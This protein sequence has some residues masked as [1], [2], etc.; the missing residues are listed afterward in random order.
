AEKEKVGQVLHYSGKNYLMSIPTCDE[1]VVRNDEIVT[2]TSIKVFFDIR[3]PNNASIPKF[4]SKVKSILATGKDSRGNERF[5]A[6]NII[7]S[8]NSKVDPKCEIK[9]TSDNT[10]TYYH[11]IAREHWISFSGAPYY[12]KSHHCSHAF[13]AHIDNF[14]PIDNFEP[15]YKIYSSSLFTHD[16]ALVLTW[17]I[18]TYDLHRSGNFPEMKN[19]TSQV[20]TICMTLHWKDDPKPLKQICFVDVE[21]AL[22]PHGTTIL[23]FNDSGYNWPFIVKKATKLKILKWIVQQISAKPQSIKIKIHPSLSIESYFLKL[24]GYVPI[25]VCASFMQLHPRSEKTL[26]KFFLEKWSRWQSWY[27]YEQIIEEL[28]VKSN[29]INDYREVA[30][31]AHISLFDLHYYTIGT[32]VSNLL[33]TYVFLPEKGL[34]NKRPVTGLDFAFLYLSII[35]TYNLSPEKMVSTLSEADKLKREN[36]VLYSIKFKYD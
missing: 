17:N 4:W 30:S 24:L 3:I 32:K 20:F 29:V 10:G 35:M 23:G 16:R 31:I 1:L 18:E 21:T 19:D 12:V 27:A 26:L 28:M 5:T 13:Y 2:I 33:G 14:R 9:T 25:D 36:K 7:S 8:Y 34:K 15:L 6:L 11:K 22:D